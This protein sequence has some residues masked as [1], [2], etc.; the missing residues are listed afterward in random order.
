MVDVLIA[1]VCVHVVYG[2]RTCMYRMYSQY[3]RLVYVVVYFL[4]RYV[5]RGGLYVMSFIKLG[6]KPKVP[7]V[8]LRRSV[9]DSPTCAF[10]IVMVRVVPVY[11]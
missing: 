8:R 5:C 2:V 11:Q 6:L 1:G 7:R 4:V 3:A 10:V 9:T